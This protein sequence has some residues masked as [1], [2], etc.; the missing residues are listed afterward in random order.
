MS[1]DPASNPAFV[2]VRQPAFDA[3]VGRHARAAVQVDQLAQALWAEL[4][5]VQL[6][7]SPAI[8]LREIAGRLREQASDLRRR[9]RLVHEMERQKITFGFRSAKGTFWELPDRLNALQPRVDGAEAADLARKAAAGDRKALSRLTKFASEAA[10]PDFAKSLLERLGADGII[11]LPAALAQRLRMDMDGRTPALG[12]DEAGVQSALKMFSKA[13]AVGTDPA[14]GG[15]AGDDFLERLK[16]QGRADHRF[17]VGGP[18]DTYTG[19]QSLA[20][21]LGLS[22]AP[23]SVRFL[24]VVG[25]DL[26]AYDREH[27]P[28][29][30]L[31]STPPP[32]FPYVPGMPH[33]R[34][35]DGS[36]PMP[37]LTG[38][39]QL[40]WALTP[41]GDRAT[42]RPPAK[43]RTDFLNGLLHV[44]G[45]SKAGSQALLDHTPAGQKNS[46]LEYLLHE[47]R[48]RWAYTDHGASLGQTMKAAMSGHDATS[49][50]LFK[51]TSDLLGRDIRG[52]FTYDQDHHLKLANTAGHADDLSG[53]RPS[54]GEIMRSHL[55]DIGG[56]LSADAL[57][58]AD[59]K[60]SGPTRQDIDALL[61]EVS[62]DDQA[63]SALV[64]DEIGRT[65]ALLD[66]QYAAR[67][68]IGNVLI[69]QGTLIGHLLAMRRESLIARGKT[70]DKAN[71]QI[72][73][74][75]DKGI[76]L[77]PVPYESLFGGVSKAV[78]S[79]VVKSRYG[80]IGDW[81][82]RLAEQGGGA[83][84]QDARTA[85]D[86]Q[87]VLGLLHQMSLSVAVDH[88]NA[89]GVRVLGE[90]F[91]ANGKILPPDQWIN[92]PKK[93]DRFVAWCDRNDFAAPQISQNLKS[94]IENSH[95]D[96][97]GSFSGTKPG[98]LRP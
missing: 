6:D 94:T 59:G 54:L 70:V 47:R 19:Y 45:L 82:S 65:H 80:K 34:L 7:T 92:D 77:V 93:V 71:E 28:S 44:A 2:G 58:G 32:V 39:L 98:E 66:Q 90:P 68:G 76:G 55:G 74:L 37:D 29:H 85:T 18:N 72:K 41:A 56:S 89:A 4:N 36:A 27:R 75:I 15:Y 10:D 3:M 1:G 60:T 31:P 81:L 20:T 97:I 5:K 49:Q 22:D 57:L 83:S 42:V 30:S 96:A 12:V 86:E 14:G 17:P 11:A 24:Q 13:L 79:E 87:A 53:L 16:E 95:D 50:R 61:A 38:L 8:R 35:E 25:A 33:R 52:Y 69:S 73:G 9:Q 26:I 62:Q 78:Y 91:A 23:F 51:E 67:G 84:D 48:A 21:L 63:F 88:A 64:W 40:G 43:G 46:D